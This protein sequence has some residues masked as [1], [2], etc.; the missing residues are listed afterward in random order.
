MARYDV[1]VRVRSGWPPSGSELYAMRRA[2]RKLPGRLRL[3]SVLFFVE[4]ECEIV[5]RLRGPLPTT[6]AIQQVRL[7]LPM[8]GLRR[9]SVRRIDVARPHLLRSHREVL[10][11]W[12]PTTR[13]RVGPPPPGGVALP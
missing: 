8:L 9:D 2:A 4:G 13:D 5:L 6:M 3:R 10:T 12:L 7:V 1:I 11:S